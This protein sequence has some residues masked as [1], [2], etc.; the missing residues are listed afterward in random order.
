M[1]PRVRPSQLTFHKDDFTKITTTIQTKFGR[2]FLARKV[3]PGC[4]KDTRDGVHSFLRRFHEDSFMS[5][6][7]LLTSREENRDT[8]IRSVW[9]TVMIFRDKESLGLASSFV[10]GIRRPQQSAC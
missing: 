9:N 7:S 2:I 8:E 6:G 1:G 5:T 4:S 10:C 3:V